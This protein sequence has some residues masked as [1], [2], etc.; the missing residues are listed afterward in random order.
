M[1]PT[2]S[3]SELAYRWCVQSTTVLAVLRKHG[4]RI[5]ETGLTKY[6]DAAVATPQLQLEAR[7]AAGYDR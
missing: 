2:I 5:Y 6:V 3:V 7:K 1:N 4:V